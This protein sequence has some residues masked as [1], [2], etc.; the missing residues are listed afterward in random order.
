MAIVRQP[1]GLF[2]FQTS[3]SGSSP[4]GLEIS[5]PKNTKQPEGVASQNKSIKSVL[6]W[7]AYTKA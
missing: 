3:K 7:L 6:G 5:C 1:E 4:Y 2:K